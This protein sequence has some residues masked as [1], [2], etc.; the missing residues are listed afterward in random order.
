VTLPGHPLRGVKLLVIKPVRSQDRQRDYVDVQH[1]EGWH[2]RM[3]IEWTD[4]ALPR[5]PPRIRG[6]DIPLSMVGL[7]K[8]ASAVRVALKQEVASVSA[9]AP[10]PGPTLKHAHGSATQVR[11]AMVNTTRASKAR[12]ARRVGDA[13]A[14]SASRRGRK[15][16]AK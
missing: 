15:G 9:P 3:P 7:Q 5:A 10:A 6:R 13:A 16:G 2:M 11:P 4:R 12:D 8:L 14:P 1:P